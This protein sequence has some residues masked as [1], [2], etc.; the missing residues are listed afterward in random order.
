MIDLAIAVYLIGFLLKL[1]SA[2]K[3]VIIGYFI[4]VPFVTLFVFMHND[5]NKNNS[6]LTIPNYFK[7]LKKSL[8]FIVPVVVIYTAVPSERNMYVIAGLYA[9][10]KV[11]NTIV[12]SEVARQAE[13]TLIAKLK[14]LE[15]EY[16]ENSENGD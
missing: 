7:K 2:L 14:E 12:N 9:G 3:G 4:S 6:L 16:L 11:V 1:S 5:L 13:R 10:D 8:F 15:N